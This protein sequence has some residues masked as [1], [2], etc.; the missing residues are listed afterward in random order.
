VLV[1]HRYA[2]LILGL[3]ILILAVTGCLLV[4]QESLDRSLNAHLLVVT[5]QDQRV[6]LQ[7]LADRVRATYPKDTVL[8]IRMPR[9]PGRAG[10]AFLRRDKAFVVAF[11]DPFTGE[12]KGARGNVSLPMALINRLHTG[13]VAGPLG[14]TAVGVITAVTLLGVVSGLYLWWPRKILTVKRGTNWRRT[15]FDLHSVLGIFSSLVLLFTL[16]TGVMLAWK[17]PIERFLVRWIDGQEVQKPLRPESTPLEGGRTLTLDEVVAIS[18]EALPGTAFI[19]INIPPDAKA[20][21]SV[22]RHFPEDKTG[23]GRSRVV[24]DQFSGRVLAVVSSRTQPMGTRLMNFADPTHVGIVLGSPTVIL[25]FLATAAL[26]GQAVTGFL[27][28]WKPRRA[29]RAGTEEAA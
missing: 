12:I 5:P 3:P 23:A 17:Q 16:L 24:V 13:R 9:D 4:F 2:G 26:A 11:L 28:W 27:I 10:T 22:M 15:N 7:S 18:A 21:Y 20:A 8:E 19:G 29:Q 1:V 14:Q 25:A 6:S